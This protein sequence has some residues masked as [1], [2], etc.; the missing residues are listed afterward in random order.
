VQIILPYQIWNSIA[1][2]VADTIVLKSDDEYKKRLRLL[3]GKIR[4]TEG[5]EVLKSVY[6]FDVEE[7]AKLVLDMSQ[8]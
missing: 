7:Q 8:G 2:F 4:G 6:K 3:W 5:A 1:T